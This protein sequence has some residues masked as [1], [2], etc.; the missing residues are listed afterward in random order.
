MLCSK[1]SINWYFLHDYLVL[2]LCI[3][4]I[5]VLLVQNIK[6]NRCCGKEVSEGNRFSSVVDVSSIAVT[7]NNGRSARKD[8]LLQAYGDQQ[9]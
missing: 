1:V 9:Q 4:N 7:I 8:T 2:R 3:C 5:Q 6:S